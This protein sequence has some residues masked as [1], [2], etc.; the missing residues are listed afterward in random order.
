VDTL[1]RGDAA[2]LPDAHPAE[3]WAGLLDALVARTVDA[4]ARLTKL[5]GVPKGIVV[6][7]GGSAS[8]PWL[9]AKAARL[10]VPLRPSTGASAV[11]RG[12]AVHAGVATGWWPSTDAAPK[13]S[14]PEL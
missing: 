13:P 8:G 2:A 4:C 1:A 14:T 9:K 3:I 12:A 5:I 11:A 7:G 6:F 10:D